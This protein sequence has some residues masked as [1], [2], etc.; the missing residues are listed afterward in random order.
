MLSPVFTHH[1]DAKQISSYVTVK[2][3]RKTDLLPHFLSVLLGFFVCLFLL[4]LNI[5]CTLWLTSAQ[6]FHNRK[7]QKLAGKLY[8]EMGNTG[9]KIHSVLAHS[10]L[11][12]QWHTHILL[13]Q[14]YAIQIGKN[15]SKQQVESAI[16][17]SLTAE[18]G[19]CETCYGVEFVQQSS[20]D[21]GT[22]SSSLGRKQQ[23]HQQEQLGIVCPLFQALHVT[24]GA[25]N[26]KCSSIYRRAADIQGLDSDCCLFYYCLGM[27][28]L[29]SAS[30]ILRKASV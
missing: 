25:C 26:F 3:G 14:Y 20:G 8:V 17:I 28:C 1:G 9:Q 12:F 5:K 23:E 18:I 2:R 6:L 13:Q 22:L 24:L 19:S 10:T 7:F 11:R 15:T 27:N 30:Q 21:L 29:A 4:V 16:V